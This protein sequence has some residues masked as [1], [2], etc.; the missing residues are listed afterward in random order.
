[1]HAHR[2]K[3]V[4]SVHHTKMFHVRCVFEF[5]IAEYIC[6]QLVSVLQPHLFTVHYFLSSLR[7][8]CFLTVTYS[9]VH[10]CP[11]CHY[12]YVFQ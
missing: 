10:L 9:H 12:Y 8:G 4:V 11:F 3:H 7:V 5:H 6:M 1:M 2:G